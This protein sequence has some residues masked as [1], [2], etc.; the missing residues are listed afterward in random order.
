MGN[1]QR[2]AAGWH[3][4]DVNASLLGFQ[5]FSRPLCEGAFLRRMAGF[6]LALGGRA[7]VLMDSRGPPGTDGAALQGLPIC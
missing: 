6:A 2:S 5:E 7:T 3:R 1:T 4:P